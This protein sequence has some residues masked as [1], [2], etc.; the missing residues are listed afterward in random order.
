MTLIK[1]ITVLL[2]EKTETG[3]DAFN[4]PIYEEKPTQ[5]HN[6]LVAPSSEQEVLDTV[7]LYGRKAVYTLAIPKGDMHNW[8][9]C[10]VRFFED[11]W[12]VI[13]MPIKG[14]DEL[15]PLDWNMK[16]RVMRVDG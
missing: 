7:E 15:I 13:G 12:L 6:V 9:N 2:Y 3:R 10:K 4:K 11:D 14:I 8:E 1:G 5:V 16:V